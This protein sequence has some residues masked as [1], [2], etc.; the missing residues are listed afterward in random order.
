MNAESIILE[1][2]DI[3]IHYGGVKAL[4]G[5]SFQLRKG[6]IHGLIGPNGAGKSTVI[7][8]ITGRRK[9][10]RGSVRLAD[11]DISELDIIQRRR[12]G[13]ARSFQR[14]SI[15]ANLDVREQ[16]VLAAHKVGAD[17]PEPEAL[18]VMEQ[19]DLLSVAHVPAKDLGYGQ[20]RRLDLALALV[21][22]PM[23]LL[24]DEP[25]AGLSPQESRELAEHL[26][27]LTRDWDVSVLLV[28]H[29]TDI[30]FDISDTVT[31]FELGRV[32]ANGSPEAVRTH[33][34]VKQAYLGSAA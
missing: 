8:A 34:R 14:T 1:A 29:D 10:T 30:L 2:R 19:L 27:Q 6:E 7:D 21:G 13:L 26:L 17:A 18:E 3:A 23:V 15:F 25:M 11:Q 4:D 16:V 32:I 5:V 22:R 9:L 33:P 12:R 31:V 28:E 24:L 20:Q